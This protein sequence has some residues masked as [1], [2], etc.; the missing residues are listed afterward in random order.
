MVIQGVLPEEYVVYRTPPLF[1]VSPIISTPPLQVYLQLESVGDFIKK[2]KSR[3]KLQL[4]DI[5]FPKLSQT[6]AVFFYI[7]YSSPFI[8]LSAAD[9]QQTFFSKFLSTYKYFSDGCT[10]FFRVTFLIESM[11]I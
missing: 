7:K 8:Y 1:P 6:I 4:N 5:S 3:C 9:P 10:A 2:T 11:L